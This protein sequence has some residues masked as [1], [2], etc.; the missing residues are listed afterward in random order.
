MKASIV[1]FALVASAYVAPPAE[2]A[3]GKLGDACSSKKPCGPG[4]RCSSK[5]KC[6]ASALSW[7]GR[8]VQ[9]LLSESELRTGL[10]GA[11]KK[12]AD[13]SGR[14]RSASASM[15]KFTAAEKKRWADKTRAKIAKMDTFVRALK[16]RWTAVY[17]DRKN[18]ALLG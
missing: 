8:H 4:L 13:V 18:H 12:Y 1:V 3:P 15:K 9:G 2:A 16:S 10:D 5:S 6:E 7:V 14:G 11:K 17:G